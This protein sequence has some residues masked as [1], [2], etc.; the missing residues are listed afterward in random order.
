MTEPH[1]VTVWS[2]VRLVG[3]H[4]WPTASPHRDYLANRH[5][6]EFRIRA[7]VNVGHYDRDIEFHD[8]R[9]II[10]T[11]WTP[12]QGVTSCEGIGLKLWQH[13]VGLGFTV[14]AVTVSEDGYDGASL[15]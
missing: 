8:L 7:D 1:T 5:R 10:E 15:R 13:L 14:A 4:R 6:H 9:D 2:E 12:E 3:W 11:W